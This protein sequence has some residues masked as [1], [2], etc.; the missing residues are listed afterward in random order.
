MA[1]P[2]ER[3]SPCDARQKVATDRAHLTARS[4]I[5][6]PRQPTSARRSYPSPHPTMNGNCAPDCSTAALDSPCELQSFCYQT[7]VRSQEPPYKSQGD[8]LLFE[9]AALRGV[10]YALTI[11]RPPETDRR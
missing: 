3:P 9:H 10:S 2:L 11:K 4:P 6:S 1:Q 8:S 5:H 7:Y